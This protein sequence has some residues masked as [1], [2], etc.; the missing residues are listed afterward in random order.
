MSEGDI[1]AQWA[2]W[3][4][5]AEP[6]QEGVRVIVCTDDDVVGEAEIVCGRW[7]WAGWLRE[8]VGVTHWQPLP[9]SV[10]GRDGGEPGS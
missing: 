3:R 9:R 6:P 5:A 10:S 2:G 4:L 8:A 7:L 1:A